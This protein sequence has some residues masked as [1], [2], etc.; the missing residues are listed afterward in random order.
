MTPYP[1]GK[2]AHTN[3]LIQGLEERLFGALQ[4][5]RNA[6]RRREDSR[7]KEQADKL[8]YERD[9]GDHPG[10]PQEFENRRIRQS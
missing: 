6:P 9:Q 8:H 4:G 2:A 5:S 10:A 7:A 3:R 1:N